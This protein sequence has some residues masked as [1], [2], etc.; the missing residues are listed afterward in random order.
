PTAMRRLT[1]VGSLRTSAAP[2]PIILTAAPGLASPESSASPTP[3]GSPLVPVEND[4]IVLKAMRAYERDRQRTKRNKERA[5]RERERQQ[6][7]QRHATVDGSACRYC[8][9][10]CTRKAGAPAEPL[11]AKDADTVLAL[12]GPYP[13]VEETIADVV[14]R[15]TLARGELELSR[16]LEVHL[17][18]LVKPGR[19][20]RS[21]AGEFE[22]IPGIPAVIALDENSPEDAELDEPWEHI[23]ADELDEKRVEP[24]SYAT[25]VAHSMIP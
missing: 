22:L 25:I 17:E 2:T 19:T 20:R 9:E 14:E 6:Q 18:Q 13:W 16:P 24:L 4:S 21:K 3:P 23:S 1:R 12:A 15:E 5:E 8:R 11:S 10:G 7:Q